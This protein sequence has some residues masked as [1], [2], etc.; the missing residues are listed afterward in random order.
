MDDKIRCE[1][2]NKSYDSEDALL[3]HMDIAGTPKNA[4]SEGTIIYNYEVV[5][6][7]FRVSKTE[8]HLPVYMVASIDPRTGLKSSKLKIRFESSLDE[9]AVRLDTNT[10]VRR[11]A[12]LQDWEIQF[13][14]TRCSLLKNN[15][16]SFLSIKL[17]FRYKRKYHLAW[18]KN[19]KSIPFT[20]KR[21]T[22][23]EQI[24]LEIFQVEKADE[25]AGI[26]LDK[27]YDLSEDEVK[28]GR[29]PII[30]RLEAR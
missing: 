8:K 20:W 5:K 24:I 27:L 30:R 10:E 19:V 25:I 9:L 3:S 13:H 23:T 21:S 1:F 11:V 26:I 29:P 12:K 4:Y 28:S 22:L 14:F 6:V 17:Y 18:T 15:Y 2:C 16:E 7:S